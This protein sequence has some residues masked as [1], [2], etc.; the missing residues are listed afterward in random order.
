MV[1]I[2]WSLLAF[3]LTSKSLEPLITGGLSVPCFLVIMEVMEVFMGCSILFIVLVW[4]SV[5]SFVGLASS[6]LVPIDK[7]ENI[8]ILSTLF[9]PLALLI[10]LI[11]AIVKGIFK[12]KTG[13]L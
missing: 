2:T 13:K 7:K 1:R 9:G 3:L 11:L 8:L 4:L 10:V 5:G 12:D 6:E